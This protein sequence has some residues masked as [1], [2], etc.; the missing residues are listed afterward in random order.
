MF[1]II[2]KSKQMNNSLL[3][4]PIVVHSIPLLLAAAL[5][6]VTVERV[7]P[8]PQCP[9]RY[10]F[11]LKILLT[12]QPWLLWLK[13]AYK[14]RGHWFN[15]WSG[16]MPGLWARSP[17]GGMQV[18]TSQCFSLTSVFLSLSFSLPPLSHK[19]KYIKFISISNLFL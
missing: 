13:S 10:V 7:R 2:N 12:F 19:N 5:S 18:A 1:S 3:K 14:P 4:R 6:D 17:V 9:V 15:S 11:I 16:H 8:P